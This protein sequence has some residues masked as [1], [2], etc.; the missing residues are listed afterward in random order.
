MSVQ[1]SI[2]LSE[3]EDWFLTSYIGSHPGSSR[4][5]AIS[6]AVELLQNQAIEE[7]YRRA[8]EEWDASEDAQLWDRTAAD[9]RE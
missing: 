7:G 3:Q 9:G 1:R 4:S 8:F 5:S 2:T 6:A